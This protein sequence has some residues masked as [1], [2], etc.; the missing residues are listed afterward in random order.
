[1]LLTGGF[2]AAMVL[3]AYVYLPLPFTPVPV[4]LQ[5]FF[6]L[7]SGIALSRWG[8]LSQAAYLV[9]GA[10]GLPVFAQGA[11]GAGRLFGPTGGYL[12]GFLA[13]AIFIGLFYSRHYLR[14]LGV[15]LGATLLIYGFGLG[16]LWLYTHLPLGRLLVA[17][18]VPFVPGDIVK[19]LLAQQIGH[20]M[21]TYRWLD[22]SLHH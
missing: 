4:T 1:V 22:L 10:T 3:S 16:Q 17:G 8:G 7:L 21:R 15:L 6:V 11:A 19:L 18:L 13:A 14:G 5:T 20:W 9:L 12:I 2:T